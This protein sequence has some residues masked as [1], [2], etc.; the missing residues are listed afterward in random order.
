MRNSRCGASSFESAKEFA[1]EASLI[2]GHQKRFFSGEMRSIAQT[3]RKIIKSAA[4]YLFSAL[5]AGPCSFND[6][7]SEKLKV[8]F[9]RFLLMAGDGRAVYPHTLS[10]SVCSPY[11]VAATDSVCTVVPTQFYRQCGIKDGPALC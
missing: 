6:P 5:L 4:K 10:Y 7:Q 1:T 3:K 9:A 2:G 11:A 8:K